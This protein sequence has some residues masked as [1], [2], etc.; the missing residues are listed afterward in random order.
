MWEE[1]DPVGEFDGRVEYGRLL[2]PGDDP[3]D[4][5]FEEQ[6][7]EDAGREEGWR[8]ARWGWADLRAG[9]RPAARVRRA[10]DRG[11]R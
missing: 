2:R 10:R 4:A 7:R 6:R 3:D 5:V 8:M 9:H 11:R 1:H